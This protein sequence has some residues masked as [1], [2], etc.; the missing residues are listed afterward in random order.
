MNYMLIFGHHFYNTTPIN[1]H[2][3]LCSVTVKLYLAIPAY[4]TIAQ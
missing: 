3:N 2:Y 4:W 1:S